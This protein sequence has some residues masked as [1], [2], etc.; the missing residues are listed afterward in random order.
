[1]GKAALIDPRQIDVSIDTSSL[2]L[3]IFSTKDW[4]L[5][6]VLQL[7]V[8]FAKEC[9]RLIDQY[10]QRV[11]DHVLFKVGKCWPLSQAYNTTSAVICQQIFWP[12]VSRSLGIRDAPV[13]LSIELKNTPLSPSPFSFLIPS[14]QIYIYFYFIFLFCYPSIWLIDLVSKVN[15]E[16]LPLVL[17]LVMN[18]L[19][20]LFLSLSWKCAKL[21]VFVWSA[22]FSILVNY[23]WSIVVWLSE[24]IL[25]QRW[26]VRPFVSTMRR[27]GYGAGLSLQKNW[28][29]SGRPSRE[30]RAC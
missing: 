3:Y 22:K 23:W 20:W 13:R 11:T 29:I 18:R 8:E 25:G 6:W 12:F 7:A 5:P 17:T 27:F 15:S 30:V 19:Y 21:C 14:F 26:M 28:S 2:S 1:M 16:P 10:V 4:Y 9:E 24:W